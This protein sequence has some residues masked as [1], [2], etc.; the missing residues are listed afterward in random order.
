MENLFSKLTDLFV[1]YLQVHPVAACLVLAMVL[2]I[3]FLW[4]GSQFCESLATLI[5]TWRK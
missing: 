1:T 5:K 3:L 2:L 4:T